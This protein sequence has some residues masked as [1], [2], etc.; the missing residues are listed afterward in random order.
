[1]NIEELSPGRVA[2]QNIIG[3]SGAGLFMIGILF[4]SIKLTG[5]YTSI[6]SIVYLVTNIG[7]LGVIIGNFILQFLPSNNLA[8]HLL[9]VISP[10]FGIGYF[11]ILVQNS[12]FLLTKW[13]LIIIATVPL[14]FIV[15]AEVFDVLRLTRHLGLEDGLSMSTVIIMMGVTDLLTDLVVNMVCYRRFHRYKTDDVV[16]PLLKQYL[17]GILSVFVLDLFFVIISIAMDDLL[18]ASY[19]ATIIVFIGLN[20]EYFLLY[21]LRNQVMTILQTQNAY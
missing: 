20:M 14:P 4:Y 12:Y 16:G 3:G 7:C 1:M 21:R 10:N 15:S 11:W 2:L 17:M 18:I 19:G 6:Q 8:G 5:D 13:D 9:V